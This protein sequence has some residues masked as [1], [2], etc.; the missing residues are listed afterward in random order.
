MYYL[1]VSFFLDL[2]CCFTR[3]FIKAVS[4]YFSIG[5]CLFCFYMVK[6]ASVLK[7]L[8]GQTAIYGLS[9]IV[10][11]LLNWLLVPIHTRIFMREEYGIVTDLYAYVG[12]LLI[13]YT[14]G[15]ETAF[16]RF[17]KDGQE[18]D[19]VYS[20]GQWSLLISSFLLSGLLITFAAPIAEWLHYPQHTT[21]IRWF[22]L[23]LAADT[24]VAL[25]FA[26]L[27]YEERPLRFAAYRLFNIGLNIVL[28]VFF[29]LICPYMKDTWPI[30]GFVYRPEVGIG[31]IFLSNLIASL[32]TLLLLLPKTLPSPRLFDRQLWRAMLHYSLPLVVVGFAGA[33]NEMLD[34]VL[35]KYWLPYDITTNLAQLGI[36]GAAYRLCVIM[37][38]FTQAFRF[39][40]EPFFFAQAKGSH[41]QSIYADTMKYFVIVGLYAF[42]GVSFFMDIV[43]YLLGSNFHEGLGVVPVLLF[44]QLL[45]GIY[46]NLAIW[47]KLTD[48][49]IFGAY[50]SLLGAVVTIILNI[51]TIPLIGYWGAALTT[52]ICYAVMVG[53]CYF[54]GQKYYPIPYQSGRIGGYILLAVGAVIVNQVWLNYWPALPAMGVRLAF[55]G[56]FTAFVYRYE[57]KQIDTI[58]NL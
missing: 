39:A 22:A 38:L 50:I 11:R 16:F 6:N 14:Y 18:T 40:A 24:L 9:S 47:Y 8:A 36:Y 1:H 26:K 13:F 17:T 43:K 30:L 12:F 32:A 33:I 19:K 29:L 25:P 55:L 34:R 31:Y 23:V 44:A 53:V 57:K 3:L 42:M 21:Y 52:L 46:Y 4:V 56:I 7:K 20:T 2:F 58:G 54:F 27:R 28:T 37:A 41:A 10:G 35:L 48:K 49:T 5:N 15:M 51:V 45:L